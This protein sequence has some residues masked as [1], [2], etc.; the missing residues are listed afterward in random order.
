MVAQASY[1]G[2]VQSLQAFGWAENRNV[3]I[4]AERVQVLVP[5]DD[6]FDLRGERAREH[7]RIVGIA[8]CTYSMGAASTASAISR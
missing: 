2:E 4:G 1:S 3:R 6:G 8:Q 5:R 7:G